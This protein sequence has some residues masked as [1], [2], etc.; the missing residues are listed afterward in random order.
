M[1][2]LTLRS[3]SSQV[4]GKQAGGPPA[5]IPQQSAPQPGEGSRWPPEEL[6]IFQGATGR[7]SQ[8]GGQDTLSG[9]GQRWHPQCP[10]RKAGLVHLLGTWGPGSN[11]VEGSTQEHMAPKPGGLI[12]QEG[13][14]R[15]NSAAELTRIGDT[16]SGPWFL[17]P[18]PVGPSSRAGLPRQ[19]QG[20]RLWAD[21][22]DHL[23]AFPCRGGLRPADVSA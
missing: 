3:I 13:D 23:Q 2:S 11:C 4:T 10:P 9:L 19:C 16:C 21:A 17:M 8:P 7:M 5:R 18:Q 20:V 12:T 22:V 6:P 14:G 1:L 15:R